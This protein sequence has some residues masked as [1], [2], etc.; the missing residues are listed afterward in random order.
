MGILMRHSEGG[1]TPE[2]RAGG[3]MKG[4]LLKV[5]SGGGR[6]LEGSLSEGPSHP[7]DPA[8]VNSPE[9]ASSYRDC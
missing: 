1:E 6:C 8:P 9:E 4:L 7:S 3:Q 5:G 2:R